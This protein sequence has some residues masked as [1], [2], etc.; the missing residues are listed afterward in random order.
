VKREVLN[1]EQRAAVEHGDGPLMVLAG[2]GTGKT[3]VL[4]HRI[5]RLVE[6]GTEPW[7]IL[8][9]TFTNKAAGE[10]RV[11]LRQLLG[12]QADAMWIGTF[13][14]TCARLLRKYAEVVGLTRSFVIFDDGDQLKLVERL[15]KETGLDEQLSPRTLLSR[16]DRAKNRGVDPRSVKTG[17]FDDVVERVFPLYEAQLRKENAVDFNDLLLKTLELFGPAGPPGAGA[18][19]PGL[20]Q[21]ARAGRG[22]VREGRVDEVQESKV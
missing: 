10:M 3:R 17:V 9:V 21:A 4:V 11:R 15:L 12:A 18:R 1:P 20:E 7:A 5:E 6:T 13:H 14:A 2:A 16:F 19:A 22:R 8:A